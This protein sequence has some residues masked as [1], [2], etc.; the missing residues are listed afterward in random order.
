MAYGVDTSR[1]AENKR[2]VEDKYIGPLVRTSMNRCIHCTRCVRF[3]TEVAGASDLGAIGRGEDME[4]TTYLEMPCARSCRAMWRSLPGRRADP[5][6]LRLPC[7]ALGTQQDRV[8]RRHGRGRLQHPHRYPW[9]RSDADP[10]AHQRGGERGVD[11][12]QDPLCVGW[13]EDPAP[14]PPYVRKD[15]RL[16]RSRGRRPSTPLPPR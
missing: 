16:T 10:A 9:P 15:G 5:Q 12:G 7:A 13:T 14:R 6:A 11:L 2:A 4:I 3:T 8:H 1:F